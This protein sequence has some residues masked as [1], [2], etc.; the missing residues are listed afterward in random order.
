MSAHKTEQSMMHEPSGAIKEIKSV[1]AKDAPRE[2]STPTQCDTS[3]WLQRDRARRLSKRLRSRK[4]RRRQNRPQ[5][6][7]KPHAP[8]VQRRAARTHKALIK[9]KT[10]GWW[11]RETSR[12]RVHT[13][14]SSPPG[15]LHV[16]KPGVL[17]GLLIYC[18]HIYSLSILHCTAVTWL[19]ESIL[20]SGLVR[21]QI[22]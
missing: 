22:S 2:L 15:S 16:W 20:S 19:T 17:L 1:P 3:W 12:R 14:G 21:G 10:K 11:K 9:K 5:V 4:R 18:Y 6:N 13:R 8:A 7:H